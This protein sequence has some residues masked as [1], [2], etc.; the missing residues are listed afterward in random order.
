MPTLTSNFEFNKPL[1]NNATDADLWGGQLNTNWDDLDIDLALTPSV[2]TA[3]FNI[4]ATEFNFTYL[5]DSSS[6]TVDGTLPST[7]PF[8]GFVVR[9]KVTDATNIITIDGD[10]N[11]IDGDATITI[12]DFV[13]L[14]SDGTN[15]V[16]G[17]AESALPF[18]YKFRGILSN[19]TDA[20]HDIDVTAGAARDNADRINISIPAFTK[21][22]DAT[23]VTGTNA[24]GL[25]SSLTLTADTWFHVHSIVIGGVA[26][27][28]FDTSFTAA[29]LVTDESATAFRYLGSVLTDGSLNIREF[30]Q[31]EKR[32]DWVSPPLDIS[33]VL[34]S[35]AVSVTLSTPIDLKTTALLTINNSG[36]RTVYISSLD[37]ADLAP[38]QTAS[39]L[40][41]LDDSAGNRGATPVSV[42][43]NTSAQV[44]MRANA[45]SDTQRIVTRGWEV[46]E[47]P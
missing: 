42:M 31:N 8:A 17:T 38:S 20:D 43:T 19:G 15:W 24:G 47:W 5:I 27:I 37:Q 46:K 22:I 33:Q 34:G 30:V 12:T 10:G 11:T 9:F 39:P 32:F 13:E 2:K 36:G 26:D 23:Y 6:N 35:T 28:G 41:S 14:I 7:I 3:D 1:V 16:K 45:G 18:G 25:S 40:S 44:R 4:G 21:Q 29:N